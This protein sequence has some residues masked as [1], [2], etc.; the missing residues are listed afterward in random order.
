MLCDVRHHNNGQ[1]VA[2]SGQAEGAIRPGPTAAY[3]GHGVHRM[4]LPHH[5]LIIALPQRTV[6]RVSTA[7]TT[8]KIYIFLS[9]SQKR[10]M[11]LVRQR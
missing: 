3:P 9:I 10:A 8:R 4:I 1:S 2:R 11:A 5:T 7:E 6:K